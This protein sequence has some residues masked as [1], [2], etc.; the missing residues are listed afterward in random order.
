MTRNYRRAILSVYD[1]TG[2]APFARRLLELGFELIASG[3][4]RAVLAQEGITVTAISEV[5]GAPEILDGRVKTLHPAI[6]AGI[7]ARDSV[8]HREELGAHGIAMIDLVVCNLYPFSDTVALP[9]TT[10]EDA[11]EQIDIGGVSLLRGAAKNFERVTVVC[12]PGDYDAVGA[13]LAEGVS[14]DLRRRLALKAFRHT[15]TYDVA[16][17][18]WLSE[19]VEGVEAL[20]TTIHLAASTRIP[21]RYGENPHQEGAFYLWDSFDP[22]FKRLQGKELSF[23]NLADVDAA[24]S[25]IT[26]FERPTVAVIKHANPCGVAVGRNHIEAFERARDSDPISAFGSVLAVNGTVSEEFVEA[27]GKLF[28]EV[29]VA[30]AFEVDAL[31]RLARVKKGCRAVVVRPTR[32]RELDIRSIRGGLLVQTLDRARDDRHSW[33]VAS[34]RGPSEAEQEA[35]AFAWEV[36]RHAKSNAIVLAKDGATVGVGVGQMNR[37]EAV[38]LATRRAGERSHGSVMGSDAFFP[39]ADGVEEAAAAG[40]TAIIQPGGSIRDEEVIAAVDR[41]GMAMMFTGVRHFRH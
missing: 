21:L 15:A 29:I 30:P 23:N 28:V 3:G 1:K 34:R 16:I 32:R 31:D 6:H 11:V 27:L 41:L 2:L 22:V 38:H 33:T 4:T 19:H 39:F 24:W 35:L 18:H 13:A 36:V 25:S 8:A 26:A 40:I 37:V 20:P 17:A 5:T 10:E 7:L 14:D 12:E 9:G